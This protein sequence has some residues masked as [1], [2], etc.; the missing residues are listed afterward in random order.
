[1]SIHPT[2]MK[3]EGW[4]ESSPQPS[5]KRNGIRSQLTGSMW[6]AWQE[7]LK[8]GHSYKFVVVIEWFLFIGFCFIVGYYTEEV[9]RGYIEK[10]VSIKVSKKNM[11]YMDH[12]T[13][14]L[15]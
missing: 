7:F 6:K 12:P 8:E 1:M 3:V 2:E 11:E 13:V 4:T 14:T 9:W 15:W 5:P 10:E